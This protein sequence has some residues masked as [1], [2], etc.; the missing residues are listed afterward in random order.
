MPTK[1]QAALG[2]IF[3]TLLLDTIG[4]G[5]IVP[6]V[7]KLIV[8]LIHG[9][10]SDA[11]RYGGWLMFSYS[12]MQFLFSPV[13]GNLSDHFGR[14]PVLLASLFGL[15]VDYLI[16]AFSPN[17][18]WLFGAR[19]FSGIFGASFTTGGAYIADITPPEKRAQNFGMIGVAFGLGFILGPV[20]GGILGQYGSRVPFFAAAG[21]SLLN[22][23]YGYFVLPESLTPEHRRAFDWK[24]AN[25]IGSLRHL[26]KYPVVAGLIEALAFLYIAGYAVQSTWTY[27]TMERFGWDTAMVG[28]SLGLV[29]L[30]T[31]IV[32]GGLIRVVIP[33][34][35]HKRAVYLGLALY[36]A[37][38]VLFAL[39]TR[40]WMVFAFLVPYCLGGIAGPALQGIIS[41][42]VGANEQ[43]E[44]Q[45]GLT[46]LM[47]LMAIISPP[48]MTNLFAY[49][50]GGS[51]PF[52][53]P[54]APFAAGAV[55]VC[56]SLLFAARTLAPH[57]H[58][59]FGTPA[60]TGSRDGTDQ[61][62]IA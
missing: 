31:A 26:R 3:T 50:T 49:F 42:Q 48:I 8:E 43:G 13:M 62:H 34:M 39:A 21:L 59:A 45:G 30:M 27:F 46:S 57:E 24:R 19:I 36:G 17:I 20:I 32:Q 10:L 9:N 16:L 41:S 51:A 38:F 35:G 52:Y 44:L 61:E 7:P 14:R 60:H 55:L 33:A 54:G 15:G 12:V 22:C 6:V 1:R 58:T 2:F 56:V 40:S 28:Y 18:L 53:F 4:I 25:P 5:I 23:L 37:G 29:G 47:S 11:S